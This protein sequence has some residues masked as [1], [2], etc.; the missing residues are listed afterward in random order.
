MNERK[1]KS[2]VVGRNVTRSERRKRQEEKDRALELERQEKLARQA[3]VDHAPSSHDSRQMR[4]I[5]TYDDLVEDATSSDDEGDEGDEGDEEGDEEGDL[6]PFPDAFYQGHLVGSSDHVSTGSTHVSTRVGPLRG[7]D[8]RFASS[9][10]GSVPSRKKLVDQTWLLTGAG[11]GGPSDHSLIPSFGGHI[12]HRLWTLGLDFRVMSEYQFYTRQGGVDRL[13]LYKFST[14]RVENLVIPD[15]PIRPARVSRPAVGTYKVVF[16][17][18]LDQ[19]WRSRGQ[20]INLDAYST[21]F[22]D[23][24]SVDPEYLKW[25]TVRTHPCIVPP[26]DG[27]QQEVALLTYEMLACQIID[28]IDPL[29]RASDED[30]DRLGPYGDMI[31]RVRDKYIAFRQQRPYRPLTL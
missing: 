30:L 29:L 10:S 19:L 11:P 1:G 20:L 5:N 28:G 9:S 23:T 14:P 7:K 18:D 21:P 8:G 25:Y 2:R 31:R 3:V 17:A 12:S 13:R 16:G 24:G 15:P 6:L 27:E 26:R 22:D 4:V